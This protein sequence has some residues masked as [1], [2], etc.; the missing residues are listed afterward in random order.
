[1]YCHI[2]QYIHDKVLT[3]IVAR[4]EA[5]TPS[6]EQR[7]SS[8]FLGRKQLSKLRYVLSNLIYIY[9]KQAPN[10]R[11]TEQRNHMLGMLALVIV[12]ILVTIVIVMS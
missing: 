11:F 7:P 9:P 12:T 1:V 2:N 3:E 8:E 5:E 6:E 10:D 4:F